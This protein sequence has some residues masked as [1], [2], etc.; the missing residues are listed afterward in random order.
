MVGLQEKATALQKEHAAR[1]QFGKDH[2]DKPDGYKIV[3]VCNFSFKSK[4]LC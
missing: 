3:D 1:L 2:M 4:A